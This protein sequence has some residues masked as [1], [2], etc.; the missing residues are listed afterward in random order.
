MGERN[1]DLMR[2][3]NQAHAAGQLG[4]AERIVDQVLQLDSMDPA[5]NLLKGVLAG[6]TQRDELAERHL[7]RVLKVQP[8]SFEALF[9]LS[10]LARRGGR[11]D[12]ATDL[13]AKATAIRP[14]DAHGLN[15]FGLCLLAQVRLEEAARV[16]AN[17]ADM[18]PDF[19]QI[20]HNLGT[21]LFL[22]GRDLDAAKAFDRAL[23]LA[24]KAVDSYLAL[25]QVLLS[26][27]N[28]GEA[29]KCARRAIELSP[30]SA[31]AHLLMA[32]ALVEDSLTGEAEKYMLRAVE[33]DPNDAK[34]QGLLGQ[35]YQSL[36]R[37]TEANQ[38]LLQSIEL[39]PKQG[40]AY[41]AYVHNNRITE[42]DRPMVQQMERVL[43]NG[44]LD[45]RQLDFLHYGLGKAFE[46]LKEYEK[47]IGHFDEANRL[48]RK[49]KFGDSV[50]DREQYA[51]DFD[52][53]IQTFSRERIEEEKLKGSDSKLPIF[54][55][56]MMRSGTT[57]A[58]QI[59]SS[60]PSVGAA[61]EQRFWPLRRPAIYGQNRRSLDP[62][63]TRYGVEYAASLAR[64]VPG[65]D[66]VTDK[67]PAN[68]EHLGAIHC[69]VPNARIIHMRRH[70]VDTC[71][72]IFATPNR[73]PVEFAYDR[74]N[75][76][77][78]YQQYTRLMDHWREVLPS[79]RFLEVRYED[80]VAD[81]IGQT[82]RML[83]FIGLEWDD[84]VL[85]HESN[86]R[87]VI[88]PSLWQVRQPI[89]STS[90]ER[91]RRYEPWLGAFKKLLVEK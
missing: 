2:Q 79:D 21:A 70:P 53:L 26:Q 69:A 35:R 64:I 45:P 67:M 10:I 82:Q 36:G 33:L 91:W 66:Y 54:I 38:H 87:N 85:T 22:L 49:L 39:E 74:E 14:A 44:G 73:V 9:W 7:R 48:A 23:L 63:F 52:W 51:A 30:N 78:A 29:I 32:S 56:G 19:A 43:S 76:V 80:L 72:S 16:F 1:Q 18:R 77:F 34:S 83:N 46:N 37:F 89:Y 68:Y 84:S 5:A 13:A 41:F 27:T 8:E 47:A 59:I 57:L 75:I 58:E 61:G 86:E 3:A 12:E 50:F 62:M 25:G 55:V 24:P 40:F 88:T 11:L 20:L 90:V 65:F 42:A 15:N 81:R 31:E 4:N 17:A 6:K 71:I 28:P 60:H